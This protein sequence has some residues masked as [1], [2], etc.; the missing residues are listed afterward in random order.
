MAHDQAILELNIAVNIGL[1]RISL[2]R[3]L[4][5]MDGSYFVNK[6]EMFSLNL[7]MCFFN[8]NHFNFVCVIKMFH[9]NDLKNI[10]L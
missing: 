8:W 6:P 3:K 4:D 7:L 5:E 10:L 1:N 9:N 2:L